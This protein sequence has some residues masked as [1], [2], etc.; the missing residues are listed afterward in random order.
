[1]NAPL[2]LGSL[3]SG[4][5]GLEL[6]LERSGLC[7]VSWQAEID[8][9]CRS[10]LAK[11]WPEAERFDDVR[12]V[13][14]ATASPVDVLCGGF[15]CQPVS[16]AG[17]RKAQGDERWLWPEFA[18]VIGELRPAIVVAENVL[19]LRTAGLV[20][21]LR[22]LA[23]LGYDAEWSDLWAYEVG[24]PHGRR[25]LFLV[26]TN[27]DRTILLDQ[28]GWFGRA[29]QW[30][31]EAV[32]GLVGAPPAADSDR[33]RRLE[34]ARSFAQLGGWSQHCGWEWRPPARVDDGVPSGLDLCRRRKALGNAV[35]VRC[36]EVV[37]LATAQAVE[38]VA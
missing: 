32:F 3:F 34:S 10:V 38:V 6:G 13:T 18:R 37:G 30:A 22:D 28:P 2:S 8:P 17:K 36:A 11:H 19:G 5:G 4:I 25:R 35:V 12:S 33:V 24:A 27:P 31:A 21:V 15:P 7:R 1:M 29:F 9:W 23:A 26:A 14:R 20:D 16:L